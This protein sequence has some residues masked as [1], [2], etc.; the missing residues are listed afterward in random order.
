MK[1]TINRRRILLSLAVLLIVAGLLLW[2]YLTPYEPE[3]NAETAMLSAAGVTVE[4]NDGWISFEPAVSSGTAV[5][6][7][8]VR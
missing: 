5:I 7:I 2:R 6:F 4:Q 3:Q 1:K 8:R